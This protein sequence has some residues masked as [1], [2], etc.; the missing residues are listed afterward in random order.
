[1]LK[2]SKFKNNNFLLIAFSGEELGLF[3]IQIFY[4]APDR[5]SRLC[6]LHDQY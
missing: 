2:S 1:M 4:R 6:K 5:G 3:G